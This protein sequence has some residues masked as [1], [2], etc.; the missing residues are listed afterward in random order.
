MK[1]APQVDGDIEPIVAGNDC[2]EDG[3]DD[4]EKSGVGSSTVQIGIA[5]G[6]QATFSTPAWS[7]NDPVD[8]QFG[9]LMDRLAAI[10]NRL[11][12]RKVEVVDFAIQEADEDE[13]D[14]LSPLGRARPMSGISSSDDG[15]AD[16]AKSM[17]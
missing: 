9:V 10:E 4:P 11:H 5:A 2:Q 8:P 3:K 16:D 7:E 15:K 1:R 12:A 14:P 17:V 6:G 13:P